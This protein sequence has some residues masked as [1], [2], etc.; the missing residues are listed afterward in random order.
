METCPS[1]ALSTTYPTGLAPDS[2]PGHGCGDKCTKDSMFK[3]II[4]QPITIEDEPIT[5]V[6]F[7]EINC[8]IY[9]I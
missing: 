2:N 3:I 1:A 7:H 4:L 9:F 5:V 6:L 8:N